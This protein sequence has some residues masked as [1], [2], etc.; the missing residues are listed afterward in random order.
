MPCFDA[1]NK[2]GQAALLLV[3]GRMYFRPA[4]AALPGEPKPAADANSARLAKLWFRTQEFGTHVFQHI[5][6]ALHSNL[7]A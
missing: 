4:K 2:S 6:R 7:S 3:H 5:C 1:R